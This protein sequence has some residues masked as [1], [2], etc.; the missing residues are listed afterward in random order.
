MENFLG[1]MTLQFKQG[2]PRVIAAEGQFGHYLGSGEG[3]FAGPTLA[4]QVQWDLFEAEG[5]TQ[6][7]ANMRGLIKTEDGV[8]ITFDSLGFFRRPHAEAMTW[9]AAAAVSFLAEDER[10]A[11]LNEAAAAWHG[12]FDMT[13]YRHHYHV[14]V[15]KPETDAGRAKQ[16]TG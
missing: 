16:E 3:T 13:A 4:G 14:Y 7:A 15:L 2:M 8:T 5:E 10:Y 9:Q 12:E 6:C 1:E 11:W